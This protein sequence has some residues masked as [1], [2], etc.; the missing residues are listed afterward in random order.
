ME[1]KICRLRNKTEMERPW[2]YIHDKN[3]QGWQQLDGS[4]LETMWRRDFKAPVQ[5]GPKAYSSPCTIDIGFLSRG[6]SGRR[7]L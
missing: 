5:R 2:I 1:N 7:W 6:Q 3:N 4:G